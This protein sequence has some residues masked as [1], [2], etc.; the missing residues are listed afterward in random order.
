MKSCASLFQRLALQMV[1]ALLLLALVKPP[2]SFGAQNPATPLPAFPG[3]QGFGALTAGG[4][5]GR[6]IEVTNLNDSG[7]GSLRAALLAGGKRIIVFRVGGTIDLK[8]DI[9]LSGEEQAYVTIAGQ[10]APGG[11]IQL[12]HHALIIGVHDVVMRYIRLRRGFTGAEGGEQKHGL[13]IGALPP[14][15]VYNVIVDHCSF[16]WQQDDNDVWYRTGNITFQW[17]IFAE[18]NNPAAFNGIEGKGFLAGQGAELGRLSFHHNYLTSNSMRNPLIV[19]D[20]P[21]HLINN[22]VYNW[23][24]FGGEIQNRAKGTRLNIIG[25]FY[26]AGPDTFKDRYEFAV[27]TALGNGIFDQ[28]PGLIYV[29]DNFGP[30]RKTAADDEWAFMGIYRVSDGPR[31]GTLPAPNTLRRL[32]PWPQAPVPV[33]VHPALES[34]ELVLRGAGATLPARDALDGRLVRE[35]HEGTGS[36]GGDNQWPVL[37]P[38]T[39]PRDSDHDGMPDAWEIARKLDP[40]NVADGARSAPSGYTWVEEYLNSLVPGIRHTKALALQ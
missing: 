37:A 14:A 28:P 34:V 39:A 1:G 26:K 24:G 2:S 18:A 19:G 20:G 23:A 4:R 7:P 6:V 8:S 9:I 27:Y 5:G 33:T 25:N 11:G 22:V 13:S 38:G 32:Q 35:F 16:G 21:T 17:N 31:F 10:S 12:R 30:H 3:A 29:R 36:I 40:A 15:P